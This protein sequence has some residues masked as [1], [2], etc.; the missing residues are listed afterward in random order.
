MLDEY[1]KLEGDDYIHVLADKMKSWEIV[2]T[3]ILGE[4]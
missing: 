2:R 1:E 4:K 3:D